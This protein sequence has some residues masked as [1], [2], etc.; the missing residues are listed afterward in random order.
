MQAREGGAERER[1][2]ARDGEWMWQTQKK[3]DE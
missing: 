3:A 1:E 2:G